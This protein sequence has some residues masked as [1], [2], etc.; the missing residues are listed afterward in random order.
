MQVLKLW[1]E[2]GQG[3]CKN[4]WSMGN[5]NEWCL[6]AAGREGGGGAGG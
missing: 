2:K 5:A 4:G 6:V 3:I 1:R